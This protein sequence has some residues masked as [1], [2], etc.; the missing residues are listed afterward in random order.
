M[1]IKEEGGVKEG[2]LK[3]YKRKTADYQRFKI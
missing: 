2:V 1:S 3:S